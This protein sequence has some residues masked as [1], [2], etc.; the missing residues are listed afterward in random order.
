[1]LGSD[2]GRPAALPD[3]IVNGTAEAGSIA[4]GVALGV[5]FALRQRRLSVP[6]VDFNLFLVRTFH[7]ALGANCVAAFVAVGIELFMLQFQP[8]EAEM[9]RFAKEVIPRVRASQSAA[10]VEK[11]AAL[12]TVR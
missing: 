11:P 10:P 5:M 6:L 7:A 12:A 9:E 4:V 2:S 3:E 1:M 8:F